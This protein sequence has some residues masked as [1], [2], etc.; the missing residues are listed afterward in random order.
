MVEYGQRARKEANVWV[1]NDLFLLTFWIYN[2]L[3]FDTFLN[4]KCLYV[5]TKGTVER[6]DLGCSCKTRRRT[7]ILIS[8]SHRASLWNQCWLLMLV[9]QILLKILWGPGSVRN[10]VSK[11]KG[12]SDWEIR[13]L[14]CSLHM[15]HKVHTYPWRYTHMKQHTNSHA[16]LTLFPHPSLTT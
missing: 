4:S 7:W 1:K 15:H 10:L 8:T 2:Y 11:N 16:P 6:A 13:M 9:G 12:T 14:T 5:F 3:S